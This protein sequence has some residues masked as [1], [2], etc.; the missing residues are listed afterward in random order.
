MAAVAPSESGCG[1]G[2]VRGRRCEDVGEDEL[3]E[4]VRS[5]SQMSAGVRGRGESCEAAV[6]VLEI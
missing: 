2:C 4:V 6:D 1:C 5:M 3:D